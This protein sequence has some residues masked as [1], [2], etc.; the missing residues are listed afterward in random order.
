MGKSGLGDR[1]RRFVG[2][3]AGLVGAAV[4]SVAL[5]A[6]GG[7]ALT[8]RISAGLLQQDAEAEA[9]AWAADLSA[10]L[11]D[12]PALIEERRAPSPEAAA[13]LA[14]ARNI[15]GV[16]RYKV[17]DRRGDLV[18]VSDDLDQTAPG[19]AK[20]DLASHRGGDPVAMSILAGGTHVQAARGAPPHGPAHYA[21]AYVPVLRNGA[22]L[23]AVE[24]YVDQTAQ[25]ARYDAAFLRAQLLTGALILA[26]GLLP[27]GVAHRQ[28]RGRR[29][30]EARQALL[31]REVD[32]RAKNI[33]SVVQS[34]LRLTPKGDAAAYTRAVEGRVAA[35]ARTRSLPK[36]RGPGPI[37]G[38]W[39]SA[40]SPPTPAATAPT[41]RCW[42][43]RPSR[44]PRP[45]YNPLPWCCTSW[46]PTRPSTARCLRR[47]GACG[48][49]GAPRRAPA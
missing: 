35:L 15:G 32:H 13:W 29:D 34:V 12:L 14:M 27:L 39:P 36:G 6:G 8:D 18:F 30:A 48:C 19:D 28:T 46:P 9:L 22:V 41:S 11:P 20:R 25:R 49:P 21:E 7:A 38:C 5:L 31:A 37:C 3:G 43:G 2:S 4:L 45:P 44:S 10:N 26:A 42:K 23:G 1:G 16:F 33:L 40:N 47:A 17:F 24:V